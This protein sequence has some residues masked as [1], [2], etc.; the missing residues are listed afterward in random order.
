MFLWLLWLKSASVACQV[1][2][3]VYFS[4]VGGGWQPQLFCWLVLTIQCFSVPNERCGFYNCANVQEAGT[5][6]T[7]AYSRV[8]NK[9]SPKI[10]NFLTFFQGLR[11]YSGL[12]R[13]YFCSISIKYKWGYAYSFSSLV[14]SKFG[15][16]CKQLKWAFN[17]WN[18]FNYPFE[19]CSQGQ[20]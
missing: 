10:I 2:W 5:L 1:Y 3:G 4:L 16:T 15:K 19:H 8:R 14:L 11:P 13:A 12:H 9:R 6:S 7:L 20:N 17:M 18:I